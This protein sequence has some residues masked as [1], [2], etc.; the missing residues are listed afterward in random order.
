MTHLLTGSIC[1]ILIVGYICKMDTKYKIMLG[2]KVYTI[3]KNGFLENPSD[4]DLAFA[5]FTARR[6]NVR[7]TQE[8]WNWINL[9]QEYRRTYNRTPI[10]KAFKNYA[11]RKN[12][13]V[14]RIG[15]LF[16]KYPNLV[17]ISGLS[18]LNCGCIG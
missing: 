2:S 10:E 3:T 5:K 12:Q 17:K 9:L 16:H 18:R 8:H 11:V 14:N 4:W 6:N 7:L 1:S 15:V 13:D